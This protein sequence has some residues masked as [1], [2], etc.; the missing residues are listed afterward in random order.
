MERKYPFRDCLHNFLQ[1]FRMANTASAPRAPPLYG[2]V[3]EPDERLRSFPSEMF[4]RLLIE[5]PDH[6]SRLADA[7]Q[8]G[9]YPRLGEHVHLLLGGAAYC[10]A[11]ELTAGLRELQLALKSKDPQSIEF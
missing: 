2:D 11:P 8:C 5:L 7:C 6:R 3:P 9:D 10:D 1:R 4:A